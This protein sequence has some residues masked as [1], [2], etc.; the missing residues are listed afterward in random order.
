M[1]SDAK[2][3]LLKRRQKNSKNIKI[4]I[5][6]LQISINGNIA[7][8]FFVQRYSSS[9]LKSKGKKTIE[10]KKTGGQWRINKE[11]I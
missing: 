9:K 11:I 2:I 8:A 5:D 1:L 10:L 4:G 3:G 6:S 7:K